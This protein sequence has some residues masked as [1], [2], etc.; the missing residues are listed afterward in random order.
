MAW[1]PIDESTPRVEGKSMVCC[2]AGD[3]EP[4]MLMWKT[5]HRIVEGRKRDP[6]TWA[7]YA[8]SYFGDRREWDD[9]DL[10]KPESAP[11]HWWPLDP[12]PAKQ[13]R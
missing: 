3:V 6:K 8:D 12:I 1:L 10:A 2:W 13:Q 5:N 4:V 11:T 7:G 9:Y